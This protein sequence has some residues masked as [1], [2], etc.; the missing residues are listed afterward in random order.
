MSAAVFDVICQALC[1][2][3]RRLAVAGAPILK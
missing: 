3:V 1:A 2:Q